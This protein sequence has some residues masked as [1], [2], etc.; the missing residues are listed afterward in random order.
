[1]TDIH[2]D[3]LVCVSVSYMPVS[4]KTPFSYT[5]IFQLGSLLIVQRP[6]LMGDNI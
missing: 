5:Y 1:M 4:V 2:S 6:K 3:W